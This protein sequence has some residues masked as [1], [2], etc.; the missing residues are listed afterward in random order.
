MA[1]IIA[2]VQARVSSTRLPGKVLRPLNGEP[3]IVHVMR[4]VKACSILDAVYLA[5]SI[6]SENDPLEQL[7]KEHGWMCYR[8]SEE[9]VLSRFV[10]VVR[11]DRADIVVRGS[12]DNMA[13]DPEV[14]RSTVEKLQR[15][16]LDVCS[17][18]LDDY[19]Y[20]FG[21]GAEVSTADCLL[22]LDE[23]TR[24][25]DPSYREHIHS[26]AYDHR[27][28]YRVARLDAPPGLSRPDIRISVDTLEEFEVMEAIYRKLAHRR[29]LFSLAELIRVWDEL[30]AEA[31]KGGEK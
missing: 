15:D 25:A 24:N 30:H 23:D 13:I 11:S 20:P 9:D 17:P 14:I 26:Y 29:S 18:F 31:I 22:R 19:T 2:I 10:D 16:R 27:D 8:G 28:R 21:A 6:K 4:R 12:G 1:R 3:A 7:A 5:T